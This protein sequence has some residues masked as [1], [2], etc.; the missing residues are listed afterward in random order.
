MGRESANWLSGARPCCNV[1]GL[2]ASHF[3]PDGIRESATHHLDGESDLPSVAR[4]L[5]VVP[6]TIVSPLPPVLQPPA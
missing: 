3:A 1:G 5:D 4:L 2:G 6:V